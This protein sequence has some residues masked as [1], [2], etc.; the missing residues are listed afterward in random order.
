MTE[1]HKANTL[2]IIDEEPRDNYDDTDGGS[3]VIIGKK[4]ETQ[5]KGEVGDEENDS[6]REFLQDEA[7]EQ[8]AKLTDSTDSLQQS[9]T[10]SKS[11]FPPKP[12]PMS[13]RISICLEGTLIMETAVN[14]SMAT[15]NLQSEIGMATCIL[16][17]EAGSHTYD[18]TAEVGG[19][20]PV[21]RSDAKTSG[22]DGQVS[23]FTDKR[24]RYGYLE[25][26][27]SISFSDLDAPNLSR[28]SLTISCE[29]MDQAA[30]ELSSPEEE[31]GVKRVCSG[32]LEIPSHSSS[33]SVLEEEK[34][35]MEMLQ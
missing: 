4:L 18:L 13:H 1:L 17:S 5:V 35:A 2:L 21:E 26:P 25:V 28:N 29:S 3:T 7:L 12:H 24:K 6:G 31:K 34:A 9:P 30:T 14:S 27:S 33:A 16:Q 15:C 32:F 20:S 19:E 10:P 8:P 23:V 11:K 22:P